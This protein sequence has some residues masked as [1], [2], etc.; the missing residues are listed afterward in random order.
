MALTSIALSGKYLH[1]RDNTP[2]SGKIVFQLTEA[3]KDSAGNVI[4]P[5][6]FEEVVLD[7]N[8]EFTINL[9]ANTSPDATPQNTAYLL[10]EQIEDSPP[11]QYLIVIDHTYPGGTANLSDLAPVT[12]VEDQTQIAT[13]ALAGHTHSGYVTQTDFDAAEAATDA[14][15]TTQDGRLTTLEGDVGTLQTDVGTLQTD[16]S[17][18]QGELNGLEEIQNWFIPGSCRAFSKLNCKTKYDNFTVLQVAA[19][20]DTPPVGVDGTNHFKLRVSD[21][22]THIDVPFSSATDYFTSGAISTALSPA[23]GLTELHLIAVGTPPANSGGDVSVS[24]VYK[25]TV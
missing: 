5:R 1:P 14:E 18:L 6:V 7:A 12:E 19:S 11:R 24:I 2:A 23:A 21:G 25:E 16:V 9:V 4:I 17:T 3:I 13:F 22:I 8:G 20:L 15:Q 10:D